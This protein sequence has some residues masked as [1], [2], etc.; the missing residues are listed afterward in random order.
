MT[1]ITG[2]ITITVVV[3]IAACSCGSSSDATEATTTIPL[4]ASTEPTGVPTDLPLGCGAS[5]PLLSDV[6]IS[7]TLSRSDHDGFD[8]Q[9]ENTTPSPVEARLDLVLRPIDD[10]GT[11]IGYG[12]VPEVMPP[13]LAL[14]PGES[15]DLSIPHPDPYG[16]IPCGGPALPGTYEPV[17]PASTV[18]F[19]AI[20]T[21]DD[22]QYRTEPITPP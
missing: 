13:T 5:L 22:T 19:V 16:T 8:I 9:L 6:G 2:L 15:G 18:G 4:V 14:A 3:V 1:R 11:I 17:D 7:S 21:V 12:E 10:D 20:V